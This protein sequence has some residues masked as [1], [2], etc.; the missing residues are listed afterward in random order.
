MT[1]VAA[2][3]QGNKI[4]MAS[5]SGGTNNCGTYMA[6]PNGKI[7]QRHDMLIGVSGSLRWLNLL[8]YAPE[9]IAP[10]KDGEPMAWFCTTFADTLRELAKN[11]GLL[12]RDENTGDDADLNLII[13]YRNELYLIPRN[14]SAEIVTRD[15]YAIGSGRDEASGVLFAL[16]YQSPVTRLI[17]AMEACAELRSEIRPPFCFKTF[18]DSKAPDPGLEPGHTRT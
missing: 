11:K 7:F 1:I 15:F 8:Q 5:D 18:P 3:K 17:S 4:Y 14:L 12:L 9:F 10:P 6:V 13:G 16:R 2:I